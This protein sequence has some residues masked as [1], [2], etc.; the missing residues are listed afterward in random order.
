[1]ITLPRLPPRIIPSLLLYEDS[2]VKTRQ[3]KNPIYIGDPINTISLFNKFE[4]DEILVF[5]ISCASKK[6]PP[7]FELIEQFASECWVPLSYGGGIQSVNDA[8]KILNSGV[9]KVVG[10]NPGFE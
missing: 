1:M 5:D 4:V 6:K 2:F 7:N 9:E 3:F 10:R 8:K